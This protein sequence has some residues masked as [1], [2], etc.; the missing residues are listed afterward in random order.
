[1][2]TEYLAALV[3][4]G[5]V[6]GTINTIAGGGSLI[7]L[8]ALIFFGLP[9][10]YANATN[11]VGILLQSLVGV[12][13]LARRQPIALR[14]L[15][16]RIVAACLGAALG[17]KLAA[18]FDPDRF[19]IVIGVA[20]LVM[21]VVLLARPK[22]WLKPRPA[23]PM[24]VQLLG[25]FLIGIYGGFLQAGVGIFLLAGSTLL[26]GEDLI[27]GNVSKNLLVAAFTCPALIIFIAQGLV[28]PLPGLCLAL[29]SMVGGYIGARLALTLGVGFIRGLLVVVVSVS[30]T[31]LLGLW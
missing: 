29:G 13:S 19:R 22:Q 24:A 6:A 20:M 27:R 16:A 31:R 3:G 1:M 17:A 14:P 15:A 10:T 25:F 30:A 23:A 28:A 7:T 9:P 18:S 21:L 26:A 5:L 11:R 12:T 2:P 4:V 8:P